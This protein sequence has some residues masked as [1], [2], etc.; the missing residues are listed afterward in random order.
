M[1]DCRALP[2]RSAMAMAVA[3]ISSGTKEE[4]NLSCICL[5]TYRRHL[6][7]NSGECGGPSPK[8]WWMSGRFSWSQT[9]SKFARRRVHASGTL[10]H[11]I[12]TKIIPWE[13]FFV[14]FEAFFTVSGSTPTSWS[15]P[16]W[17]HCLRPWSQ[18]PLSTEN[19]RKRVFSGSGAPNFYLVSQTPR[20]RGR[21]PLFAEFC[22]L[23][24]SRKE[25]HFQGITRE[26]RNFSENNCFK[27]IFPK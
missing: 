7:K 21:G 3:E 8:L 9:L 15:G 20:P 12:I 10:W 26:I 19:A 17:D 11:E 25:R 23:E 14:I 13:L 6:H 22:P 24:M 5:P 2:P 16:F 18:S 27:I 4:H 1:W